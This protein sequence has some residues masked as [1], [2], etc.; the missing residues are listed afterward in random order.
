M[1]YS[2]VA[3]GLGSFVFFSATLGQKASRGSKALALDHEPSQALYFSTQRRSDCSCYALAAMLMSVF[4][5]NI[6]LSS[7]RKHAVHFSICAPQRE[8]KNS[9]TIFIFTWLAFKLKV[10]QRGV[11][12]PLLGGDASP[13]P[14]HRN[15]SEPLSSVSS[16]CP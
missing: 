3:L 14:L 7:R 8:P 11:S 5:C 13:S 16:L 12:S 2:T 4:F 15:H 9:S 10:M 1:E 6:C